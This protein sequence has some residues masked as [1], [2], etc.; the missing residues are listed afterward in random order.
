MNKTKLFN[1][2]IKQSATSNESEKN[3]RILLRVFSG[4]RDKIERFFIMN[5]K[6]IY[7]CKS[8]NATNVQKIQT[9]LFGE[10]QN[11]SRRVRRNKPRTF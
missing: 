2:K 9:R 7:I 5:I 11:A 4:K 8:N 3:T 10:V 1:R 6:T